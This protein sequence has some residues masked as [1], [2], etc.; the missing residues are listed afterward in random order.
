MLPK[1]SND[2]CPPLHVDIEGRSSNLST[3]ALDTVTGSTAPH[4]ARRWRR[5][6]SPA[7]LRESM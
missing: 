4:L 2:F 1:L 6:C 7:R 5:T 3:H